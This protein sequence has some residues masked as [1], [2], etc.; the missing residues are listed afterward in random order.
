MTEQKTKKP[1]YGRWWAIC[2]YVFIG[3]IVLSAIFGGNSPST[4]SNSQSNINAPSQQA[5]APPTYN[6]GDSIQAGDFTWK[7][8]KVSTASQVG[9]EVYGTLMGK[10]ADGIF[11]ILDVQV[12]NTG[13]SA[14]YLMDSFVKLVDDQGREFS[15]DTEASIWIKPQGSGLTFEQINPGITKTGKI[16]YD[17][18]QGLK[19][20][21][22][23]ISNNLIESSVYDVKLM[24]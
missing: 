15:P 19:V 18:P 6:I 8:T 2:L 3:L 7:I 21:N 5:Q 22:L 4:N 11:V 16:I 12:T 10:K 20:A 23:K 24:F 17:I 14:K 9:E 13:K 1:W